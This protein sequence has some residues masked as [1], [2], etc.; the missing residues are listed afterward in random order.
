[1]SDHPAA[2]KILLTQAI[3]FSLYIFV[4]SKVAVKPVLGLLDER[5]AT[6]GKAFHDIDH[7]KA[8][9]QQVKSDYEARLARLTSEAAA[10]EA[11]AQTEGERIAIELKADAEQRYA[12]LIQKARTDVQREIAKA[13]IAFRDAIAQ[14]ATA[15]AEEII[16][17]RMDTQLQHTLI[18][19]YIEDLSSVSA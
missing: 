12:E 17:R 15:T 6:I 3:G 14:S 4:L 5:K 13:R 18:D 16:R 9:L 19:R 8:E 2:W 11:S 10:R 7:Q 1:M